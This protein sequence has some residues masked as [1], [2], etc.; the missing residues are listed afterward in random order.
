LA[1]SF[2]TARIQA[3]TDTNCTNTGST[4]DGGLKF[5]TAL[6][7]TLTNAMVINSEGNVGIGTTAPDT[8]LEINS[9][10][11][12]LRLTYNDGDGSATNYV[13]CNVTSGGDLLIR[14]SGGD[15]NLNS[16][17][18]INGGFSRNVTV[19]N[20]ATYDLL[21]TD[22]IL[23]VVYTAT[24]AVTSLTLMTAQTTNGRTIVVKDAGGNS[25]S[26]NITIDTEGSETID[27]SDTAVISSNY[28]SASLY[29]DGNNWFIY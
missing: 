5:E 26:N 11:A 8:K 13:D 20:T 17:L 15:I 1:G 4:Q 19:I 6:D 2:G 25:G 3:Y 21:V 14:P 16:N 23:S 18:D 27:G 10:G 9:M 29:C 28:D 7:G 22:D 24:G 12:G